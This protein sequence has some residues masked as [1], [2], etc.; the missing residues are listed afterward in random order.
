MAALHPGRVVVLGQQQRRRSHSWRSC[1]VGGSVSSVLYTDLRCT[2]LHSALYLSAP[3]V[4]HVPHQWPH[5]QLYAHAAYTT[6]TN[7]TAGWCVLCG[8]LSAHSHVP[9][10]ESPCEDPTELAMLHT[11]LSH[12]RRRSVTPSSH[13]GDAKG[14]TGTE[15]RVTNMRKNT[16][17]TTL[18]SSYMIS[19]SHG[20]VGV[21]VQPL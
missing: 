3:A 8:W 12:S 16:V 2:T 18:T 1:V 17:H 10:L 7:I 21:V 9:S 19:G 14:D 15:G 6:T 13:A 20:H 4:P 5:L 11:L